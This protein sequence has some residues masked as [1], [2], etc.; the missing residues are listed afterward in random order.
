MKGEW[1]ARGSCRRVRDD[2][3]QV[4]VLFALLLPMLL[5]LSA[6]VLDVG[7]WYVHAKNL[8]TKVDAAAFAGGGAWG[9]PCG[10]DVDAKSNNRRV[11]TWET[12][13]LPTA[14][15]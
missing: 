2:R 6:V 1:G 13:R 12:I 11:C 14:R 5:A 9:F 7:N 8:Q 4:A 15:S 3:G 10:P